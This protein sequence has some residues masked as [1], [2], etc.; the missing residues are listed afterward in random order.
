M[1]KNRCHECR[2]CHSASRRSETRSSIQIYRKREG[3]LECA[4][5]FL[6]ASIP[7]LEMKRSQRWAIIQPSRTLGTGIRKT[8]RSAHTRG[9]G[10]QFRWTQTGR[11]FLTR[12]LNRHYRRGS[13]HQFQSTHIMNQSAIPTGIN[14]SISASITTFMATDP[15]SAFR[16]A[17]SPTT[18]LAPRRAR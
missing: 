2:I 18:S 12:E 13:L 4:A 15:H 1:R 5:W 8:S 10:N 16:N 11:Q 17:G 3:K 7:L 9:I 6:T 14:A